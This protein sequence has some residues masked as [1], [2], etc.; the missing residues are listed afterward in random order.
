MKLLRGECMKLFISLAPNTVEDWGHGVIYQQCLEE[1]SKELGFDF[2]ALFP[3]KVFIRNFS[4]SWEKFF[5]RKKHRFFE[6]VHIFK[7][8][9][10]EKKVLFF[11]SFHTADLLNF[12]LAAAF[13]HNKSDTVCLFYRYAHV[14]FLKRMAQLA[15]TKI[16]QMFLGN[17]FVPLTDS[18]LIA[19]HYRSITQ[20]IVMP[21]PHIIL[22][23]EVNAE[24]GPLVY[25]W[26]GPPR[27]SKGWQE[28]RELSALND[29]NRELVAATSSL[30]L[31]T[32]LLP[33]FL[34]REEYEREMERSNIILLPYDP[35]VYQKGTSGIFVEAVVAGK[36]PLVKE[37]SWLAYELGKFGLNELIVDW[38]SPT[39]FS[40]A[41]ALFEKQ[42]TRE[43]LQAMRRAYV[44]FHSLKNYKEILEG[45][46]M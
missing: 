33:D 35:S 27:E 44:Q 40:D 22:G 15:G 29:G 10:A 23:K 19:A 3:K 42:E 6:F 14:H 9:R 11:E 30:L 43:K 39:F 45:L 21:I 28:L 8:Y 41:R 13:F 24:N 16:L 36:M 12:T 7:R 38:K 25:W 37:G 32:T 46:L 2:R 17:R 1:I 5:R 20:M 34:S 26:P 18:E 31:N 4:P